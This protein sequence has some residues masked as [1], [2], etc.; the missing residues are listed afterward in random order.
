MATAVRIL[1]IDP[2][3]WPIVIIVVDVMP[4]MI[5]NMRTIQ[6]RTLEARMYF[7][8]S[9]IEW[10]SGNSK[11]LATGGILRSGAPEAILSFLRTSFRCFPAV[12][13]ALLDGEV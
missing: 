8:N 13:K 12:G 9:G 1:A 6:H 11:L 2:S 3:F 4:L 7:K 10:E 5:A